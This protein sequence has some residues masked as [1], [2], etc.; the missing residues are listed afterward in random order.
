MSFISKKISE[1]NSEDIKLLERDKTYKITDKIIL[2]INDFEISAG[3]VEGY[4]VSAHENITV[5]LD[6]A[7]TE[8]LKDE[9]LAREFVNRIQNLRKE[10]GLEVTDK[11]NISV[12]ENHILSKAIKNNFS[13]ICEE[14]LALT[15]NYK[16]KKIANGS[17][18]Q[19]IEN[20]KAFVLI[21]KN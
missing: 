2:D 7:I 16:E 12:E 5:A 18:I 3:D 11:I 20:L 21:E 4:S 17:E 8:E 6:I 14:T 1:F 19:L 15:L 10:I 13:Y 9:G